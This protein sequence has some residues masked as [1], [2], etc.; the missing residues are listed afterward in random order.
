M[1]RII[2]FAG[3]NS[4]TS[5]NKQLAVHVA[6]QVNGSEAEVL[7]LNDYQLPIYG[8]D[9]E[10]EKGIPNNAHEFLSKIKEADGVILSL[11]EH[12]GAYSAVF[13]NLLDWMSRIDN[14]L[15]GDTPMLLMATS[16]GGRGGLTVLELGKSLFPYIG[17]NIVA[18]FSLPSFG[19]NF[20]EKGIADEG[21]NTKLNE[22]VKTF[23]ES[24]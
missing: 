5:I 11:A 20:T 9:H 10:Q 22:A 13:K 16:P 21:L 12:N 6:Q 8:I 1:K 24:I 23:E 15:F 4:K 2:A 18:D 14:K 17:G 3:S 7:D 19:Q